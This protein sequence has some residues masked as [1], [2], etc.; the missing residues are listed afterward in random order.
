MIFLVFLDGKRLCVWHTFCIYIFYFPLR[1]FFF[2]PGEVLTGLDPHTTQAAPDMSGNFPTEVSGGPSS[3]STH[4][5]CTV[6]Y[7]MRCTITY[8][9]KHRCSV[10]ADL[11][12]V[13][14]RT[15]LLL[16]FCI[17]NGFG[18]MVVRGNNFGSF[19]HVSVPA[20]FSVFHVSYS[21]GVSCGGFA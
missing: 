4:S 18:T 21:C 16:I 6:R 2:F 19:R 3:C 11:F 17:S 5:R 7:T 9:M 10:C 13:Y 12:C 14:E 20:Q 15:T 8:T 1:R